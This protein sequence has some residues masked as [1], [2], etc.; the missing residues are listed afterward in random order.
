MSFQPRYAIIAD[1]VRREENGKGIIIGAYTGNIAIS[2]FP[3]LAGL[4]FWI[5]GP[6]VKETTK[7][8]LK[9]ELLNEQGKSLTAFSAFASVV[10]TPGVDTTT[11]VVGGGVP[12][13]EPGALVLLYKHENEW[14]ELVRKPIEKARLSSTA[15]L[16]P[17]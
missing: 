15:P 1:D 3:Y 7:F 6:A 9:I 4:S 17:P 8:E 13:T 2:E 10:P 5:E 16:P 11:V 14:V 12:I